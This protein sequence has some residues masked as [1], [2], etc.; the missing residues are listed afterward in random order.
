MLVRIAAYAGW[1]FALS[2]GAVA[3]AQE[4]AQLPPLAAR[5]QNIDTQRKTQVAARQDAHIAALSTGTEPALAK[6]AVSSQTA[7]TLE[8]AP[9][10]LATERVSRGEILRKWTSVETEIMSVG[11]TTTACHRR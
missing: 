8:T 6:R 1:F 11:G 10:G 2:L 7:P 4:T 3:I 9:F 5:D